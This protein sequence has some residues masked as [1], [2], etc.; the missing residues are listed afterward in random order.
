[1]RHIRLVIEY[2][3]TTLHGWQRQANGATVQQHL[4]EAL[5]KLL[6]HPAPVVGASRTDAGVHARGQIASF[7]TERTIPLYGIRRGLNSMLPDSIAIR[8]VD[9][10][11]EDFH[12]RFS[13]SGK[14]YRYT[15]LVRRDRSP[16]WRDRAWHHPEPLDVAAMREAATTLHGQHDFAAFRAAG[17]SAKTSV[18]RI[19]RIELTEDGDRLVVDVE[20]NA[21][22]RNMVR[23]VV[24][25]LVDVGVGR[26][27]ARQVP[28]I[29]AGLDRVQAG[30]TAPAHGLELVEVHYDRTPP[31]V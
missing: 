24:G 26:L 4:E 18:R 28:G 10:V 29:L 27:A 20:G 19:D 23:I 25:T 2:D 15:V 21:F 11:P 31:D 1:M 6:T 14:H 17:C 16:H 3:G 8:E 13:A 22:L 12:P 5:A 30:R 7:R 9:E